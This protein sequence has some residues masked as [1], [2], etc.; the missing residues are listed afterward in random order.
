MSGERERDMKAGC[1]AAR[2]PVRTG[3]AIATWA[4]GLRRGLVLAGLGLW[5]LSGCAQQ[6]AAP[7]GPAQALALLR[8][9]RAPLDC[10]EACL[11]GWRTAQPQ[12]AQLAASARWRELAALVLST[13]YRDDLSLYYLGR[14]AEGV[15]YPGAAAS[16]YQQSLGLSG[17]SQACAYLSRLCGGVALPRAASLR[18]A[19]LERAFARARHRRP[20]PPGAPAAETAPGEEPVPTSS[21]PVP[22]PADYIEPPPVPPPGR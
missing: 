2:E 18:L 9:G 3:R 1:E 15:G 10:G 4:G 19:A 13:R 17:T 14:A 21:A 20:S 12:A 16:Y 7:I 5:F 22:P 8:T 6:A 11:G